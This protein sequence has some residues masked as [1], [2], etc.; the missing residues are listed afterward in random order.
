MHARTHARTHAFSRGG[1]ERING[2]HLLV[3]TVEALGGRSQNTTFTAGSPCTDSSIWNLRLV[4]HVFTFRDAA[5]LR[6]V[7]ATTESWKVLSELFVL[8]RSTSTKASFPLV[9]SSWNYISM[10]S[11]AGCCTFWVVRIEVEYAETKNRHFLRAA[12]VLRRYVTLRVRKCGHKEER[13]ANL[14]P[15]CNSAYDVRTGPRIQIPRP[16]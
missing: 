7:F 3:A 15:P 16:L 10:R 14:N 1:E 13:E 5:S 4:S 2:I 12:Y 9:M 8:G 6:K 11:K